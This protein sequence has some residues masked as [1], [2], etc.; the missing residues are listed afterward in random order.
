MS[1]SG[2]RTERPTPRRLR[3]ARR[4]G[5]VARSRELSGAAA[6]A[7]SLAA[8][9]G[10]GP[11]AT[12]QLEVH[13]RRS[14]AAAI[15]GD[16]GPLAAVRDSLQALAAVAL[17]ISTAALVAGGLAAAAQAGGL[18]FSTPAI[19]FRLER[20]DPLKG[21]CRIFSLDQVASVL[22]GLAKVAAAALLAWRVLSHEAR[23]LARLPRLEPQG[24]A[25][26]ACA[27]LSP[28]AVGL[29]ALLAAFGCLDLV[30]ARRRHRSALRM[31]RDEVRRDIKE[32][33]GDPHR[34]AERQRRHR[35]LAAAEPI[36]RATC[37]VVNPTHVAVAL[38]HQRGGDEPPVVLAKGTGEA[39]ARIRSEARRCGVPQ[40]R[41]APLARA[42]FRL[43]EVGE[44][45]PEELY[46]AAAV[47][48]AHVYGLGREE[49]WR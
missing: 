40:V 42:L 8:I 6:L 2:S 28:L 32:Q 29:T 9:A 49:S 37:L 23:A 30:R 11:A 44:E 10:L 25:A 46:E 14:L 34:K 26:A 20:L 31:T 36:S 21:L 43:A 35:A 17:P 4:R 27:L 22:M 15:A 39:A 16:V 18:R 48:L 41:E 45:I 7:G 1:A 5:E 19:A 3:D 24:A 33:E 13:L 12:A 47:V 38:L